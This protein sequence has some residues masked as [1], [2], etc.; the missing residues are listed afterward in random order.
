MWLFL[1]V[2]YVGL[3]CVIVVFPDHTHLIFVQQCTWRAFYLIVP[4]YGIS[5]VLTLFAKIKFFRVYLYFDILYP[6][7][8]QEKNA[9]ENVV[10]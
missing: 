3:Q 8:H 4:K 5:S 10:Y 9:Y 6:L 7:K 1:A 2:A